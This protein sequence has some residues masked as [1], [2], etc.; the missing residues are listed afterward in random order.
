MY[1]K[2]PGVRERVSGIASGVYIVYN[3]VYSSEGTMMYDAMVTCKAVLILI[4]I[5]MNMLS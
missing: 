4:Y 1:R 5:H 2:L 3:N